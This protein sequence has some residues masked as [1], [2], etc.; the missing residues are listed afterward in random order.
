MP[1][2]EI[3][4]ATI[5]SLNPTWTEKKAGLYARP[6]CVQAEKRDM[7]PFI[8]VAVIQ[9]E[10]GWRKNTIY[11]NRNGSTDHGLMQFNCPMDPV[12]SWRKWWCHPKRKKRLNSVS[13]GISAGTLELSFWRKACIRKHNTGKFFNESSEGK[14]SG[15]CLDCFRQRL[16]PI[17]YKNPKG[18][19]RL[20]ELIK[21]HWWVKHY[22]YR[23]RG[24]QLRVLYVY[25]ALLLDRADI[26]QIVRKRYY[27]RL[28]KRGILKRCILDD[29][30]CLEECKTC[31]RNKN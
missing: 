28:F 20:K 29:D 13:G 4:A 25:R 30:M 1:C 26:Y 22:N 5:L 31:R 2:V 19:D 15:E 3:I 16:R 21:S 9:H 10:S 11:T 6:I 23:N 18:I 7:D 17:V 14:G 12:I 24:Y 27:V 8:I